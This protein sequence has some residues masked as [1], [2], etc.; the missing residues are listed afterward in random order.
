[1][2]NFLRV[3]WATCKRELYAYALSPISYLLAALFLIVQGYS[4]WL[5]CQTLTGTRSPSGAVLA[6]FF[7]G[8]LLYYL[9]LLFL[10]ALLTMRLFAEERQRGA[11]DLLLS[12]AMPEGALLCGKFLGAFGFYLALWLPTLGY[13]ALLGLYT[14]QAGGLD[15]GALIGGYLGTLL[16]GWSALSIGVLSSV[17]ATSPLLSA[18]L[19]FVLLSLLLLGG[20]VGDLSDWSPRIE[21]LL[22][23]GNL[24]QHMDELARGILDSRRIVYHLSLGAAA[25]VFATRWLR[26]RPG[27]RRGTMQNVVEGV[28]ILALLVGIN[29]FF[30][31]HPYRVDLTHSGEHALSPQ[32]R[33]LLGNLGERGPSVR[34]VVLH[35]ELGGRDELFE[36]LRETLVQAEQASAQG[37]KFEWLDLDHHR[38][39]ARL[40]A[41]RHHIERDDLAQGVIIVESAGRTKLFFRNDLG[42]LDTALPGREPRGAT[43]R[44]EIALGTAILTVTARRTPALCFTRGH[45]EAEHDSFTGSGLSD[46]GAALGRENFTMRSLAGPSELLALTGPSAGCD[47]VFI[48]GPERPFLPDEAAALARYLDGGGRLLVLS[49]A[50]LDRGLHRFLDTGLEDL[51]FARGVRLLQAVAIDPP[52]RL[53]DSL[54]FVVEN[55]GEHPITSGLPGRRTLWPLSR[56]L[57]TLSSLA[58]P[59]SNVPPP[60]GTGHSG[61]AFR[62]HV[63]ASTSS[64]GFGETDLAALRDGNLRKD[65]DTDLA[66]PLPLAIAAEPLEGQNGARIVVIGSTQLAWNDSLVL[67]NRDFLLAAIKWLADVPL[68]IDI[69]PRRPAEVR[70]VLTTEQVRRLFIV[71]V[72]G[73]PLLVLLLGMGIRWLR[74]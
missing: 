50:L 52:H 60:A 2:F 27:D 64:A 22:A 28:F 5:L 15:G 44:G 10:V 66:G 34:V 26:I 56:P 51:L 72:I 59:L 54:A 32:L 14:G 21:A 63:L 1:M 48:A 45:G 35:G 31:R 53:G 37:L 47:V 3:A 38:E 7:G 49:G 13:V 57:A 43:Y 16:L 12:T 62:T 24:F 46:L 70:L 18:A 39:R 69:A 6:Y 36:R 4:F 29:V 9:F 68:S 25:L 33:K 8:T 74:R 23:Y 19:T 71:I 55:Y 17:L 42:E 58:P 20:L 65:R 73:V 40:L 41:S 30:A 11:L 67:Y 61:L